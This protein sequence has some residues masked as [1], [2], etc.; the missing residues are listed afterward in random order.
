MENIDFAIAPPKKLYEHVVESLE[1]ALVLT[2]EDE[3]L[4]AEHELAERFSVSKAVIREALTVLKDRGLVQSRNGDG[5]YVSRPNT[6]TV[7][8]AVSR[9]IETSCI[10]DE[11]LHE[12]RLV[13]E[14]AT[15][16]LAA[17]NARPDDIARLEATI[18]AMADLGMPYDDW[19]A[20][21]IDFH[22]AMAK[23][24]GNDLLKMFVEMMMLLLK[25]Y[26]LKGL[27][28]NYDQTCTL[29]EHREIV[30][31]IRTGKPDLC[32]RAVRSHIFSARNHV[33]LYENGLNASS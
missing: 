23:A 19:L 33:A 17:A 24:G 29:N 9:I 8:K 14:T 18:D 22:V 1:K 3:K 15:V 21:D 28:S 16:R 31:A 32:E 12:T 30:R 27:Y 4:P 10:N 26:M 13:L 5:S 2:P 25:K 20:V 6:E 11:N 7:A